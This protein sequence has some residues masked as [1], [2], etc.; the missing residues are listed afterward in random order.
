[1][2]L[3]YCSLRKICLRAMHLCEADSEYRDIN[4]THK[5][6]IGQEEEEE[7]AKDAS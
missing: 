6:E 4:E 1:M 2:C 3:N 5:S 7:G